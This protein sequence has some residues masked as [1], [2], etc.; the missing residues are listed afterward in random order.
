MIE[1]GQW[2]V[3]KDLGK[4]D[5]PAETWV[6]SRVQ[7]TR[8]ALQGMVRKEASYALTPRMSAWGT[9]RAWRPI[10]KMESEG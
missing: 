10:P 6:I 7:P 9:P 1:L 2:W 3:S 8:A 4:G 5:I